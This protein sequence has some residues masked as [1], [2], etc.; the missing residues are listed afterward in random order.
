MALLSKWWTSVIQAKKIAKF[1]GTVI[2]TGGS[3]SATRMKNRSGGTCFSR[4]HLSFTY[5]FLVMIT[6]AVAASAAES[7]EA[8][9]AE[10]KADAASFFSAAGLA[11]KVRLSFEKAVELDG[12]NVAARSDLAE[13]YMEA[14]G[15]MGGGQDKSRAQADALM[16]IAPAKA[17]WV[18]GRLAEKNKDTGTA[19]REYKAAL[20]ATH[21]GAEG[22]LD[23]AIFYRRTNRMADLDNAIEKLNAA[24]VKEPD[25]LVDAA[26]NLLRSEHDLPMAAQLLKRYLAGKTV[27]EAP[28]F[29]AHTFLG[30]VY[31]KQGDKKA[32]ALEFQAAL[33]LASTY[34][35]ARDGLKRVGA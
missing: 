6:A 33:A 27:E 31:E 24:P 28:A 21:N 12:S 14:P 23:L 9:L 34:R 13:F 22:W 32:A 17:H 15:I 19:E 1:K 5:L 7:P 35:P 18:L 4:A 3:S 20:D 2:P 11:K 16:R 8:L 30:T 25:V 10:G 29:R 26:A